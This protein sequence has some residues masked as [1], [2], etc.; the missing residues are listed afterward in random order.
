MELTVLGSSSEGNAYVLQTRA[1][2]FYLK[3]EYHSKGISSVGQ[4]RKE[5]SRLPHYP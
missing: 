1:K 3:L 2:P 5:N 4:Q